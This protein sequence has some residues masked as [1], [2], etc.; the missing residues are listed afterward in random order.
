MKMKATKKAKP[1]KTLISIPK[2]KAKAQKVFNQY[3]RERDSQ[4]GFFTCISCGKTLPV[5]SM[6]AGHYVPVKGGS[7]L[8]MNEWNV[9]GE[10]EGCNC[11]DEF[12]LIGY[13]RNLISKIGEDAV[14]WLEDHR[15]DSR[16]WT[17]A[18]LLEIIDTYSKQVKAA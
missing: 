4:G 13:R 10:C 9:N 5:S 14:R 15:R 18:E 12:H 2:L 16:K 1:K 7:Y 8:I 3:I 6:N 11:F 17:R